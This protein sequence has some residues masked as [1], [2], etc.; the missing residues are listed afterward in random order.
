MNATAGFFPESPDRIA[1]APGRRRL[2]PLPAIRRRFAARRPVTARQLLHA[3]RHCHSAMELA[4]RSDRELRESLNRIGETRNPADPESGLVE[5]F[6]ITDESIRRR[7]G[8]WRIF[9]PAFDRQDLEKHFQPAQEGQL[10]P[11]AAALTAD[12]QL[13]L[14]TRRRVPG[15]LARRYPWDIL[16][17]AEFYQSLARRDTH[18]RLQFHLP[19][20][21]TR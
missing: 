13:I 3:I 14:A 6:A 16:L 7:L 2:P 4:N 12:E 10:A 18:N 15:E 11:A 8:Y 9:D 21:F 17:P 1:A 19:P 20:P 5:V